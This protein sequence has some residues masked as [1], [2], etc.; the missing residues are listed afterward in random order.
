LST[1]ESPNSFASFR[2]GDGPFQL[3][4]GLQ[5]AVAV[6]VGTSAV[7]VTTMGVITGAGTV[8]LLTAG[9]SF[10]VV[11]I[12]GIIYSI[13]RYN[14]S[15]QVTAFVDKFIAVHKAGLSSV[16]AAKYQACQ[17][18]S[19]E[20]IQKHYDTRLARVK[21][22]KGV[23]DN[24]IIQ[25]EAYYKQASSQL[26]EVYMKHPEYIQGQGSCIIL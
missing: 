14:R 9:T 21:A 2:L 22:K 26:S 8:L 10:V 13:Y 1:I 12:G 11:S 15:K 16:F 25:E 19:R 17:L 18:P 23:T 4:A 24:E 5:A 7:V 3:T 20:E 6:A